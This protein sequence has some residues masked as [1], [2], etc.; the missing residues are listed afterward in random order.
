M[1]PPREPRAAGRLRI[2]LLEPV[3]E[4]VTLPRQDAQPQPNLSDA[5][6]HANCAWRS[7]P[8]ASTHD[9]TPDEG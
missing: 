3:D 7:S 6:R 1:L 4:L 8:P 5:R 9:A 2:D